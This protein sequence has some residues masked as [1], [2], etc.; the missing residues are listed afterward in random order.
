MNRVE[1]RSFLM[2][3]CEESVSRARIASKAE[4]VGFKPLSISTKHASD[5]DED[6]KHLLEV[7]DYITQEN[8][9]V[10]ELGNLLGADGIKI[11]C[12]GGYPVPSQYSKTILAK[13]DVIPTAPKKAQQGIGDV[14]F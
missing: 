6:H 8:P 2:I 4:E 10:K 1:D 11:N 13:E 7:E 3:D 14:Y 12:I 9:K 5:D